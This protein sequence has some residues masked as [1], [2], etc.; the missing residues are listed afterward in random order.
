LDAHSTSHENRRLSWCIQQVEAMKY[1]Q[2]T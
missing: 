2:E 1:F